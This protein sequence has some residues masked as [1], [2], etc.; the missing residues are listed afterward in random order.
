MSIFSFFRSQISD[1]D[2]VYRLVQSVKDDQDISVVGRGAIVR[3]ITKE[4]R[5]RLSEIAK[6]FAEKHI[7]TNPA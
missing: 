3:R 5:E 2:E 7:T 6:E 1:D 4:D